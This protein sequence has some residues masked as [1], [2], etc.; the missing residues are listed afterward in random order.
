MRLPRGALVAFEGVDGAG[1]TTQSLLLRDFLIS[2]GFHVVLTKEPTNGQFG[3]QIRESART[4]RLPI[5]EELELFVKDRRE[6]V[7]GVVKP[8]LAAGSVVIIDRYYFS[9]VAYQGARGLEPQFLLERNEAFAPE[10][11][12]LVILDI[13]VGMGLS[14]VSARGDEPDEFEHASSLETARSIFNGLDKPYLL[15]LDATQTIHDIEWAIRETLYQGHLLRCLCDAVRSG[16][17]T[18]CPHSNSG[19]CDWIRVGA[20]FERV[21]DGLA[22]AVEAIVDDGS[23]TIEERITRIRRVVR[24]NSG[25]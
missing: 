16:D 12:L 22:T 18:Y 1:K 23:L 2:R 8:A 7:E 11:D 19:D 3:A 15:R 21:A 20:G 14:R 6:H 4:G 13:D 17:S 9:T 5:E 24:Q 25:R 10:P